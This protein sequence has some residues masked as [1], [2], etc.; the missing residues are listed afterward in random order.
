MGYF[1]LTSNKAHGILLLLLIIL[2]YRTFKNAR[3]FLLYEVNQVCEG[4]GVERK[5]KW[6]LICLTI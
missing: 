6:T 5:L 1:Q 2:F 3:E 4:E